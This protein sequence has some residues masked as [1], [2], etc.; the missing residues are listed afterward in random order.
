MI[1]ADFEN[2]AIRETLR[3]AHQ[4]QSLNEIS[5]KQSSVLLSVVNKQDRDRHK[6]QHLNVNFSIS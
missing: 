2:T 4:Y 5:W 1:A 3:G 6:S